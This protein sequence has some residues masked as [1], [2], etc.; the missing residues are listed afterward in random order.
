LQRAVDFIYSKEV[1]YCDIY[2]NNLL[3]NSDLDI[4]VCDFQDTYR[5]LDG[6]ATKSVRSFLPR[7]CT[8]L[9]TVA[10]DEKVTEF[11]R[12]I[13]KGLVMID[14]TETMSAKLG[15]QRGEWNGNMDPK[16]FIS[17]SLGE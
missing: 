10:A 15:E 5:D 11:T 17:Q 3:L 1:I 9:P 4:R 6:K 16:G 12:M 7:E 13:A 2:T 8:G 14:E